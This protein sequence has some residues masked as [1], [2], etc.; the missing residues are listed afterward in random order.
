MRR[1]GGREGRIERQAA[2][3]RGS[4]RGND[5]AGGISCED[6]ASPQ[7]GKAPRSWFCFLLFFILR[8]EEHRNAFYR[9]S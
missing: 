2:L 4:E 5:G 1:G 3:N 7:S 8:D 6:A 9:C